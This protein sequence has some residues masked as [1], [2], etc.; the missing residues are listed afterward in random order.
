MP[1]PSSVARS[2]KS[3]VVK[4]VKTSASKKK[5]KEEKKLLLKE[6]DK[7]AGELAKM[8]ALAKQKLQEEKEKKEEMRALA[9]QKRE[10]EKEKKRA[11][12]KQKQK[13]DQYEELLR[14]HFHIIESRNDGRWLVTLQLLCTIF[15]LN[16]FPYSPATISR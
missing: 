11:L 8:R 14:E 16:P 5:S 7:K 3:K 12:A 13:D 15:R 6:E 1:S 2:H 10:E 4:V 9:K